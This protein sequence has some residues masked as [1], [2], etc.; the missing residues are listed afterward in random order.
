[1]TVKGVDDGYWGTIYTSAAVNVPEGVSVYVLSSL[2]DDKTK[3]FV[4]K[5]A[6]AGQII[7]DGAYLIASAT[8]K[9]STIFLEGKSSNAVTISADNLLNGAVIDVK[10]EDD[11]VTFYMLTSNSTG[12]KYGFYRYSDDGHSISTLAYKAYLELENSA[13]AKGI[14]LVCDDN[15]TGINSVNDDAVKSGKIYN[16]QGIEVSEPA[17]GLY[18][19]NGKKYIK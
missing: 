8:K 10:F 2:N 14:T 4:T 3:G 5:V 1:M 6:E 12:D 17:N 16:L 15:A 9:D 19:K 7:P 11:D 13:S 18:I